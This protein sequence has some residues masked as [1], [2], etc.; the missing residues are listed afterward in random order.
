VRADSAQ[1]NSRQAAVRAL[2]SAL[3]QEIGGL[4]DAATIPTD[5]LLGAWVTRAGPIGE[6]AVSKIDQGTLQR[7][8]LRPV[9]V[10][11]ERNLINAAISDD[12]DTVRHLM[13]SERAVTGPVRTDGGVTWMIRPTD[14]TTI[15]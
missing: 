6:R 3:V 7:L 1:A 13:T 8:D 14:G 9:F 11:M 2:N 10:G 12:P 5:G 15:E 4:P